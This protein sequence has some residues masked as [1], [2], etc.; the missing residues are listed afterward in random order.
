MAMSASWSYEGRLA[1]LLFDQMHY[2]PNPLEVCAYRFAW[3]AAEG[4]SG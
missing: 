2:Y 4:P 1:P 3:P